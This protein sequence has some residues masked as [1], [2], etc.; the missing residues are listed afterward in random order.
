MID[1][2]LRPMAMVL[3]ATY[4][5][6]SCSGGN[7]VGGASTLKKDSKK[8]RTESDTILD[9]ET[10][11]ST[12]ASQPQV[13]TGS[14][15]A[16]VEDGSPTS[17]STNFGCIVASE[18]DHKKM[19]LKGMTLNI[20]AADSLGN[21]IPSNFSRDAD[22]SVFHGH[23]SIASSQAAS[24]VFAAQI[25]DK[26]LKGTRVLELRFV[27]NEKF[28]PDPYHTFAKDARSVLV[29]T[30]GYT[31]QEITA[32][33]SVATTFSSNSSDLNYAHLGSACGMDRAE[34]EHNAN[35]TGQPSHLAPWLQMI[36]NMFFSLKYSPPIRPI[37]MGICEDQSLVGSASSVF[38]GNCQ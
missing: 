20:T 33:C 23:V 28:K 11:K 8:K 34:R 12:D 13:V 7:F 26:I 9:S 4:S 24:A 38:A 31:P 32:W 2:Y 35:Y 25:D 6:L 29:G 14:Y 19:E 36:R 21:S 5:V 27:E 15:L 22:G 1:K 3:I 30:S 17:G 37:E 16:C 10:S 18:K